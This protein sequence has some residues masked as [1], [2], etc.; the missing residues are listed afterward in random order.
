MPFLSP[1]ALA[2]AWPSV[3]PTSS[4]VWWPSMCR[5]P[6]A[7]MSRSI[8]PWRAIWSS[9]WSKKPMPVAS[10]GLA[11]AVEVDARRVI[12][13][14]GGVA[15]DFVRRGATLR[16]RGVHREACEGRQHLRVLVGGA[17]GQAQ[18]VGQ[19]WVHFRN[20]LDQHAAR[21][22]ALEGPLRHRA[23]APGSCW[24]RWARPSRRG[25]RG[26]RRRACARARA[27]ISAACAANTSACSSANSAHSQLST[28]ML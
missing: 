2:T 6:L 17:D 1:T 18:A 11:G 9:M 14:L 3:M 24:R 4:T 19:Q 15:G 28:L 26:Q 23:R 8:R 27:R 16:V 7:S 20:V 25:M 5:S 13:R 10:F 22:H 12:L 21:L